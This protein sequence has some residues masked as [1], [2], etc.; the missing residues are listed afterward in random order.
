MSRADDLVPSGGGAAWAG[1]GRRPL[2]QLLVGQAVSSLGDWMGTVALMALVLELTGS[3]TAVG[4]VLVLRL[5]PT[6][7]AGPLAARLVVRW[8]RRR[9][10]LAT[11]AVRIPLVAVLPWVARLWWVYACAFLVE[12]AG[13]VFL[14]A[15][16]ALV[17][18]LVDDGDD[19]AMANGL[20]LG[21]SYG[22]IPVGAA[23][24]AVVAASAGAD[25]GL[26]V[27]RWVF[28]V[29]AVTFAVSWWAIAHL[30]ETGAA[31]TAA[32]DGEADGADGAD[33]AEGGFR[34]ALRLPLVR[35]LAP[36]AA[37][38][39]LGLGA[40]FS[41]GILWVRDVLHA[42]DPEFGLLV[43]CFGVGAAGGLGVLRRIERRDLQTVRTA[44][45]AQ[46]AVVATMSLAPTIGLALLGALA[47]GGLSALILA[48]AMELLQ[49]SLAG[50]QRVLAFTAFHVVIRGGLALAAL[51]AGLAA[52][53]LDRGSGAVVAHLA[54]TQ[55]ILL[56][57][58][59]LVMVVGL[60]TVRP[61]G[62][63]DSRR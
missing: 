34:A 60:V 28:A 13:M 44:I 8:S 63:A 54:S 50:R 7:V 18:D 16:D 21:T 62:V 17:P 47:F 53:L 49:S 9:I 22:M 24:Y 25:N 30:P 27:A 5:A 57:S 31:T 10:M 52:D 4:G 14:P 35:R 55:V 19:L 23:L 29:D 36:T 42:S 43:A 12:L 2:N 20:V 58:G 39:A 59:L 11:D 56:A 1:G 48:L 6:V 3:A 40:L 37:A 26:A 61:A 46:G 33:G 41:I 38:V 32:G 45:V 15:R 51:A